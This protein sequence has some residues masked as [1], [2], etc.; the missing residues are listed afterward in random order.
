MRG[1]QNPQ[2]SKEASSETKEGQ[3]PGRCSQLSPQPSETRKLLRQR[4]SL[5]CLSTQCAHL[6]AHTPSCPGESDPARL[7]PASALTRERRAG[8][9]H[10]AFLLFWPQGLCTCC[11][12]C[13]ECSAFSVPM[14]GSSV[15]SRAQRKCHPL[16]GAVSDPQWLP[17]PP[18]GL[19]TSAKHELGLLPGLLRMR[20]KRLPGT[21]SRL[22]GSSGRGELSRGRCAK[23]SPKVCRTWPR[24]PSPGPGPRTRGQETPPP[25]GGPWAAAPPV[26]FSPTLAPCVRDTQDGARAHPGRL[27]G[28]GL[29]C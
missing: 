11:S 20:N 26:S 7:Q 29:A 9:S 10:S 22:P 13:L 15:P 24:R 27:E 17:L 16:R 21:Q 18:S 8:R 14:A 3:K 2:E 23:T 1:S 4:G 5:P 12:F 25:S 19:L 28:D 6:S